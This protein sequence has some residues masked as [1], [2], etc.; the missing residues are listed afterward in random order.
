[1]NIA[2]TGA[3]GLVGRRLLKAL[4]KDGHTLTALSRHAGTNLPPGVRLSVWDAMKGE[5]PADGLRDVDAVIHLAGAP[6]A[7]RWSDQAKRDI[8]ESRVVGTRNLVRG[9]AKLSRKPQV[10]I[11]SSAVGYYGSRGNRILNEA[12]PPGNDFLSEVCVEW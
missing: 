4:A 10:L 5:P 8:R 7:Q 9:L 12:T 6:V 2:I 11:S 3:S 1:V